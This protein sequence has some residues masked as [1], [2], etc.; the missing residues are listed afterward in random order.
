MSYGA[1]SFKPPHNLCKMVDL[2]LIYSRSQLTVCVCVPLKIIFSTFNI[3]NNIFLN[4]NIWRAIYHYITVTMELFLSV[5]YRLRDRY[6]LS[7]PFL[8]KVSCITFLCRFSSALTS[9]CLVHT[10]N[11]K[12]PYERST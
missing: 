3:C 5:F 10:E 11:W 2:F 4:S 12:M 6:F 8:P 9:E 7:Q 1:Y